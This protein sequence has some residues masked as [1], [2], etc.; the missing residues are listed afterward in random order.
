MQAGPVSRGRLLLAIDPWDRLPATSG[1]ARPSR[2]GALASLGGTNRDDAD[3]RPRPA[4]HDGADIDLTRAQRDGSLRPDVPALTSPLAYR[5][6][7]PPRAPAR[8]TPAEERNRAR[9]TWS[10]SRSAAA[11]SRGGPARSHQAAF[12]TVIAGH[13]VRRSL[14]KACERAPATLAARPLGLPGDRLYG[15]K[16]RY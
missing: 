16:V 4:E 15:A 5:A 7:R 10:P 1:P 3:M 9:P 13:S 12:V 11:L 2:S 8:S 6:V 14:I